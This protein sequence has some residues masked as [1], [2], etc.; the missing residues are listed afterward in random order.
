MLSHL[1]LHTTFTYLAAVN[2][3][4]MVGVA[5][6]MMPV[7]TAGLNQLPTYLI[8]HG[9][10]MNNTMRQVAGAVGTALLVTVMTNTALPEK[11]MEGMIHGVN[12]SFV[13]A[14]IFSA[15]ALVLSFFMK[16]SQEVKDG[17]LE[18]KENKQIMSES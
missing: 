9:T 8:S 10:A 5:M 17:S 3:F 2:A 6:V 15:I 1:T 4:R 12:I 16:N 18:E 14:G 7:T 11:G 13:V